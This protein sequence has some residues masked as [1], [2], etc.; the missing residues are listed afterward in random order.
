MKL[1][2]GLLIAFEGVDKSGK[3]TQVDELA[4]R[5]ILEGHEVITIDFPAYDTPSGQ[6]IRA[7]LDD[8]HPL[9][10][11]SNPHEVQALYFINRYEQ[12]HRIEVALMQGKVVICNRYIYSGV[13]YGVSTGVDPQWCLDAQH[14]LVQPD[15]TIVLDID[16]EEYVSRCDSY[17][18]LDA[19]ERNEQAI[20]S[21]MELYYQFAEENEWVLLDGKGD[22]DEIADLA[23]HN[24]KLKVAEMEE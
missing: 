7:I 19:F 16:Y 17:E 18:S 1:H 23:F 10:P 9:N 22:I 24:V 20:K 3:D 6:A 8:V 13:V 11:V 5:L 2:R 12:Q 4:K 15:I 14:S 21:A